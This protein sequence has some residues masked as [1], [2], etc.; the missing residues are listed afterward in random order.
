M[1]LRAIAALSGLSGSLMSKVGSMIV[2]PNVRG[3]LGGSRGNAEKGNS[4][5]EY[6]GKLARK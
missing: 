5:L 3:G 1:P 4:E 6:F 2:R